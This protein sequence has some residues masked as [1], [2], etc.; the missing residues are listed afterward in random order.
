VNRLGAWIAAEIGSARLGYAVEKAAKAS[1]AGL[2]VATISKVSQ[3]LPT[4]SLIKDES[5]MHWFD[6]ARG[7]KRFV[8]DF[9]LT[10][11]SMWALSVVHFLVNFYKEFQKRQRKRHLLLIPRHYINSLLYIVGY[12]LGGSV[13]SG[14]ISF[15][16]PYR[17]LTMLM[18]FI[19]RMVIAG[20]VA[21]T[22]A[23]LSHKY[24]TM[25]PVHQAG[26]PL[27][28]GEDSISDG[29]ADVMPYVGTNA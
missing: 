14:I 2:E 18:A 12:S 19:P 20:S 22:M 11:F 3:S 24:I 8:D 9:S 17:W 21:R 29:E 6:V 5:N 25:T 10:L 28:E 23:E 26:R 16:S 7:W 13:V 4:S 1:R 15:V 27:E